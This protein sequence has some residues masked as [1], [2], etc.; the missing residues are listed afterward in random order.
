MTERHGRHGCKMSLLRIANMALLFGES[1]ALEM[2]FSGPGISGTYRNTW[3]GW[4]NVGG[5][6]EDSGVMLSG[7]DGKRDAYDTAGLV[8]VRFEDTAGGFLEF[9]LLRKFRNKTLLSVVNTCMGSARENDGSLAWQRGHCVAGS[10]TSSFGIPR[11]AQRLLIGFAGNYEDPQNWVLFRLQ[12]HPARSEF[13]YAFGTENR[14]NPGF[15][16]R[17]YIYGVQRAVE[18]AGMWKAVTRPCAI[19]AEGCI[20]SHNFPKFYGSQEHCSLDIDES[21]TGP[22]R[23][24]N[25][26]TEKNHDVLVVNGQPYSGLHGP[27]GVTPHAQ[28]LWSSDHS[29]SKAGWRLCPPDP[30]RR[31][32]DLPDARPTPV[33]RFRGVAALLVVGA[34]LL[35]AVRSGAQ[36]VVLRS[37]LQRSS[38]RSWG[39]LVRGVVS[40]ENLGDE[41]ERNLEDTVVTEVQAGL[42]EKSDVPAAPD[43]PDAPDELDELEPAAA[44]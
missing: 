29:I 38:A 1:V 40:P 28:I 8:G 13:V 19:D 12:N 18:S 5:Y 36:L 44:T 25:F 41:E 15:A 27:Q 33:R 10:L 6:V 14:T 9:E 43:A 3:P 39:H 23:V 24:T 4:Y 11:A 42:L 30:T 22:L 17:V 26:E 7:Y 37:I 35:L 34:V 20:T 32:V 21:L 2:L 31:P 16:G